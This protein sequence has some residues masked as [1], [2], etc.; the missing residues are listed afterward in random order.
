[1]L[2]QNISILLKQLPVFTLKSSSIRT[3]SNTSTHEL[4]TIKRGNNTRF[5]GP[6]GEFQEICVHRSCAGERR[7]N[8]S[9]FSFLCCDNRIKLTLEAVE[10]SWATKKC[11]VVQGL[12]KYRSSS[13]TELELRITHRKNRSHDQEVLELH[14]IKGVPIF[15]VRK[16]Q[17]GSNMECQTSAAVS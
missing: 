2:Q 15:P 3:Y 10:F 12:Y 16:G 6:A 7:Q 4:A 1:M 5:P 11:Y 9:T 8:T 13:T 17:T 14:D